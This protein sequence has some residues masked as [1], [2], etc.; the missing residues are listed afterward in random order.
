M[1]S[2]NYR[3]DE[4]FNHNGLVFPDR[5]PHP[6]LMEVKK[7]YQDIYF[8]AEH[9]EKGIITVENDFHFTNL[10]NYDFKYEVLKNGQVIKQGSFDLNLAPESEKQVQLAI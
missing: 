7:F 6:G 5:I 9:P 4:N 10:Q 2:Q 3:N 1:G 8:K